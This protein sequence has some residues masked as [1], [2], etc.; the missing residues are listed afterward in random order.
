MSLAVTE[1]LS[2]WPCQSHARTR[3]QAAG[4]GSSFSQ[5]S[6]IPKNSLTLCIM[7]T[8]ETLFSISDLMLLTFGAESKNCMS[9]ILKTSTSEVVCCHILKSH[10]RFCST[11]QTNL[12]LCNTVCVASLFEANAEIKVTIPVGKFF[13]YELLRET[14]QSDFEP[15]SKLYGKNPLFSLDK[16]SIYLYIFNDVSFLLFIKPGAF[17]M[18]P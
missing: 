3:W 7:A 14:F 4:A 13:T 10:S 15:L 2:A 9:L 18:T 12:F 6:F 11:I 8:L 16:I 1:P 17:M 5:A